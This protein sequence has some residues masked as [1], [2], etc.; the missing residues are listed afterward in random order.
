MGKTSEI[1][2]GFLEKVIFELSPLNACNGQERISEVN[3]G[4]QDTLEGATGSGQHSWSQGLEDREGEVGK[5]AHRNQITKARSVKLNQKVHSFI[6]S[7]FSI[8]LLRVV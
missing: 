8:S 5:E 2:E 4:F 6:H 1:K 7:S 3:K